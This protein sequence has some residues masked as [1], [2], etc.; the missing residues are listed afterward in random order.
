MKILYFSLLAVVVHLTKGMGN[1]RNFSGKR[2]EQEV[3]L[4]KSNKP[5]I[6]D[7]TKVKRRKKIEIRCAI[8][9]DLHKLHSSGNIDVLSTYVVCC[10]G[11]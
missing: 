5:R 10:R 8:R 7:E 4:A 11:T 1:K 3:H 6:L 9:V 2:R